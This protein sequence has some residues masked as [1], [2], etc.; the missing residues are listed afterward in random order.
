M[1]TRD[2]VRDEQAAMRLALESNG[3]PPADL[4]EYAGWYGVDL[5][6]ATICGERTWR[7]WHVGNLARRIWEGLPRGQ[8][9]W[10]R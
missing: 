4:S 3:S 2:R 5:W 1:R 6:Y 8:K 7:R 10:L 9:W